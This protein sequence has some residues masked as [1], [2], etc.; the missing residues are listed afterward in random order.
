[1]IITLQPSQED[2]HSH[3]RASPNHDVKYR[4]DVHQ[5][6]VFLPDRPRSNSH[7]N[8]FVEFSQ[9]KIMFEEM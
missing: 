3:E 4:E 9:S 5:R 8:L 7:N 1:M 2:T 6:P